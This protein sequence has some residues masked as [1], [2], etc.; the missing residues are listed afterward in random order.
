MIFDHHL[1]F[2]VTCRYA[3]CYQWIPL[4]ISRQ[5]RNEH[6]PV[7]TTAIALAKT[8]NLSS[9]LASHLIERFPQP[10]LQ[11]NDVRFHN[12]I[13]STPDGTGKTE[14]VFVGVDIM[15]LTFFLSF[16]IFTTLE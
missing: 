5:G 1:S 7:L 11:C 10:I 12:G 13:P 2:T 8:L 16:V 3:I 15:K 6:Y 4:K 14:F 9:P